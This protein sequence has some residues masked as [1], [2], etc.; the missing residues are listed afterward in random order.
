MT[1][2][3]IACYNLSGGAGGI[4]TLARLLTAYSLS[5]GAPYSLLGTTPERRPPHITPATNSDAISGLGST[6]ERRKC[7][8]LEGIPLALG[9]IL[10]AFASRVTRRPIFNTAVLHIPSSAKRPTF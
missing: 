2:S 9:S 10:D 1:H 7:I 8:T 6:N 5:R 3:I 4:R